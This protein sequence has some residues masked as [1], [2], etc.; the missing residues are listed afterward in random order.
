MEE[1]KIVYKRNS[2]WW[3]ATCYLLGTLFLLLWAV[4][5]LLGAVAGLGSEGVGALRKSVDEQKIEDAI[6]A[7]VR[8]QVQLVNFNV[9]TANGKNRINVSI[10]NDA[11]HAIEKIR[12]EISHLNPDGV[13]LNSES[14]WLRDINMVFPG[15]T[16]HGSIEIP[17]PAEYAHANVV[18][19][20]ANFSIVGDAAIKEYCKGV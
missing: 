12:L 11:P 13:P 3:L 18:V 15:D 2:A 5:S 7:D 14:E 16:A 4:A 8:K 17:V 9:V 1:V 6:V 19:R 20:I 10:K